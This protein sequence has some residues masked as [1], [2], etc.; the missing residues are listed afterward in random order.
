VI[1]C[2]EDIANKKPDP[3]G[4]QFAMRALS[5]NAKECAYIGDAPEDIEM[6]RRGNVITI[7]V[8]SDYPSSSR[9][10]SAKP[11]IYLESMAELL[12]HF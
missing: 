8:R 9:V 10:L 1:V 5:A 3:E 4:L 11:D 12:D 2:N 6:G 7:G